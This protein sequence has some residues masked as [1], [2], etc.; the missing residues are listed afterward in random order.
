LCPCVDIWVPDH[1][2]PHL[3]PCYGYLPWRSKGLNTDSWRPLWGDHHH[4]VNSKDQYQINLRSAWLLY[5]ATRRVPINSDTRCPD[6]STTRRRSSPGGEVRPPGAGQIVRAGLTTQAGR[7]DLP[8]CRRREASKQRTR[9]GI[10]R[11]ASRLSS[12]RSP[13]IRP[14]KKFQRL[15]NLP[16]RGL[17]P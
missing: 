7:S 2:D 4:R 1:G 13:G 12:L 11:P 5:L 9:V 8:G 3:L 17:Y 16:L 6:A 15:P 14:M 10:A